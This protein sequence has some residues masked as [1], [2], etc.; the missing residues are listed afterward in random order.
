[1]SISDKEFNDIIESLSRLYRKS[2]AETLRDLC[3][4]AEI[5]FKLILTAEDKKKIIKKILEKSESQKIIPPDKAGKIRDWLETKKGK[6]R[7]KSN[8]DS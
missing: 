5:E 2:F 4:E 1:M 3:N 8:V 7:R 6:G